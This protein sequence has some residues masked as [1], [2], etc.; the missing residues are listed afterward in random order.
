MMKLCSLWG[1]GLEI[2]VYLLFVVKNQIKAIDNWYSKRGNYTDQ[3]W[4]YFENL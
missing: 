4:N 2:Q 1:G 3:I